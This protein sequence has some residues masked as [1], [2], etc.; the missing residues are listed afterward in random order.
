MKIYQQGDQSKGICE[1]CK[2]E[3]D[4]TFGYRDMSFDDGHGL[5]QGVLVSICNHCDSVVAIPAQSLPALRQARAKAARA[6]EAEPVPQP[7]GG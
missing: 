4:T 1:G 7:A 3:V 6:M 2:A 5:A